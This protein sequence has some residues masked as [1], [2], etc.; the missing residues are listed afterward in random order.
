MLSHSAED[1]VGRAI[2]IA[3]EP[4]QYE[5]RAARTETQSGANLIHDMLATVSAN[6]RHGALV[7]GPNYTLE[8]AASAEAF[9]V[10]VFGDVARYSDAARQLGKRVSIMPFS[11]G[12]I[13]H[14]TGSL[15]WA[16]AIGFGVDNGGLASICAELVRC[17]RRNGKIVMALDADSFYAAVRQGGA[18]C[19]SS[20]EALGKAD[21]FNISP[22]LEKMVRE[23]AGASGP[24]FV[25]IVQRSSGSPEPARK[26]GR[27]NGQMKGA[28]ATRD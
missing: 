28:H 7:V 5:L 12:Y 24:I 13:P 27:G 16:C 26:S 19:V 18:S 11:H 10:T 3:K 4:Q 23:S 9:D 22:Q 6:G 15:D 1:L 17:V 14:N 20:P 25:E 21:A 8:Q 2:A